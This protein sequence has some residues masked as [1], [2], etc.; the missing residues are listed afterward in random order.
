MTFLL[1]D[2]HW[3]CEYVS[4]IINNMAKMVVLGKMLFSQPFPNKAQLMEDK[5]FHRSTGN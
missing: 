5:C 4:W 3:I 1:E 2:L